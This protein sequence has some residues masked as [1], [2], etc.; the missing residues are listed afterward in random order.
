MMLISDQDA[1]HLIDFSI[2]YTC[3]KLRISEFGIIDHD[4]LLHAIASVNPD[5]HK[6]LTDFL[7]SYAAWFEFHKEI[8]RQGKAGR[9]STDETKQLI[10]LSDRKDKVRALI[11]EKLKTIPSA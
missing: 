8:D 2:R 5:V 1:A 4:V 3:L 9:L 6:L 7:T 10:S 11:V